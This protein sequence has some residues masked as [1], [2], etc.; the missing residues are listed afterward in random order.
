[1]FAVTTQDVTARCDVPAAT[2]FA[3]RR[4]GFVTPADGSDPAAGRV[5]ADSYRS[6]VDPA[7]PTYTET[8]ERPAYGPKPVGSPNEPQRALEPTP[9]PPAPLVAWPT[10]TNLG[11]LFDVLV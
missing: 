1:M 8:G 4:G 5:G 11:T 2:Y 6:G 3:C 10:V 9:P 7:V